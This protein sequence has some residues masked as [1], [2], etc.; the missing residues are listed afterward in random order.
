MHSA[1]A[2]ALLLANVPPNDWW[3]RKPEP[4]DD[5]VV[6]LHFCFMLHLLVSLILGSMVFCAFRTWCSYSTLN[7]STLPRAIARANGRIVALQL[8]HVRV[9]SIIFGVSL[10][11]KFIWP[12]SLAPIHLIFCGM[13][14]V[15]E[16]IVFVVISRDITSI[17]EAATA[18]YS[19]K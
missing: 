1:A 12:I 7:V 14:L 18:R 9:A 6:F 3:Y 5:F 4:V 10:L 2:T 17:A 15:T 16:C 13:L 11:P 19:E 8:F